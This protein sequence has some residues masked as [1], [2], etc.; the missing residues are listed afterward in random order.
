MNVIRSYWF[1]GFSFIICY[2]LLLFLFLQSEGVEGGLDSWNHYLI[3]KSAFNHPELLI[4][5]WNKPVFTWLT[6]LITQL[7]FNALIWFNIACV[8]FSGL[9]LAF[10]L[11]KTGYMN[12]WAV[13][14]MLIFV[15]ILF[16]NII[17]GL[18]EP[19]NILILSL[20]LYFWMNKQLNWALII[21]SF[22]PYVRTEGFVILGAIFLLILFKKE[23]KSLLWLFVGSFIMNIVGFVITGKPFWIITENPYL[24]HEMHGTFDPGNGSFNHFFNQSRNLFGLPLIVLFILGHVLLGYNWIKKRVVSDVF[25]LSVLIFWL[26]FMAHTLIFYWGILGSHGLTRVMAVIAPVMVLVALYPILELTKKFKTITQEI[27]CFSVVLLVIFI[28]YKETGYA[29]P[30]RFNEATVKPDKSQ[31]NFIKAGEWLKQNNLLNK[32]I[33]HQSPYFNVHFNKDPFDI[34]NSYYVWSIDKTNDWAEDGVIIIWDGFSAVR[35]GNMPLEWLQNNPDYI[36]LH[37]IEGFEK[38]EEN[39]QQYDIFIFKKGIKR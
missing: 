31:I 39:P 22:L 4:D 10:G 14:P 7:G 3:S 21:A 13:I 33:I 1:I 12:T 29:K 37:Y 15:P 17:S 6:V 38:P 20:I 27:V 28:A 32:T 25:F 11:K 18:T 19:L 26:Y 2:I 16:Q 35:E 5:Q 23:Y 8:L 30:H 9:L 24:K 36:L 34:H